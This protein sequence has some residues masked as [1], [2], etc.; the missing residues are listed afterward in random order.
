MAEAKASFF[1]CLTV[2]VVFP[3]GGLLSGDVLSHQVLASTS[4]MHWV[5]YVFH[6][7][8]V[9]KLQLLSILSSEL[10]SCLLS[11]VVVSASRSFIPPAWW[12]WD[13]MAGGTAN[14]C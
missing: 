11:L 4:D 14:V 5:T 2:D 9:D 6:V 1:E 8:S 10:G 12:L 13:C 7:H 3:L